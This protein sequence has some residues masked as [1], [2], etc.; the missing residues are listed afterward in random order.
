MCNKLGANKRHSNKSAGCVAQGQPP[1]INRIISKPME[2]I[3]TNAMGPKTRRIM[4]G[5]KSNTTTYGKR[6]HTLPRTMDTQRM[7]AITSPAGRKHG[8]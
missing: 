6:S 5:S 7:K 3:E 2:P 4:Q 8:K 1:W